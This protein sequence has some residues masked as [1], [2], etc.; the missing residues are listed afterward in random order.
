[1]NRSHL[2]VAY[3]LESARNRPVLVVASC[4]LL[5]LPCITGHAKGP[6][7]DPRA[8][9]LIQE[10]GLRESAVASR[11]QA[12]WKVP[13]RIVVATKDADRLKR[14]QAAA[15]GVEVLAAAD[16]DALA[17]QL[18]KAEAVIGLCN[19]K[20]LAAA[21]SLHWIQTWGVGVER[22]VA[23]PDLA[24]RG[25]VVTNMQRTS[26]IPIAEHAIAMMLSL[27]RAMPQFERRQQSG[28]WLDDTAGLHMR[29][30]TGQTMLVVGLGGIGTEVARRAHGLGMHVTAT[31]NSSREG[32]D[33]VDKVG[34]PGE[35]MA[36]AAQA[37]VV[38]NATPLT[39]ATTG[40][41]NKTFFA[42][43]K[44]GGI[45]INIARGR[46]VVTDDLLA[47]LRDGRLA[48]AGLDVT[49]PE[50]LPN[51]HPLWT[52]PNVIITPHVASESESQSERYLILAAENIRRYVAGEPLLN[53]VD[54][55]RGY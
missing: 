37:D 25:I 6:P 19:A 17:A 27:S 4:A 41:F 50:P 26:A 49:D 16:G 8:I 24:R 3:A 1:M 12:G 46:S 23:V 14:L 15:P 54:I 10:L 31:R 29:E 55:Q 30:L 42:T 18:E 21:K 2:H 36:L 39:A 22:C 52:M 44:P 51:G 53:V 48:G 47:A 28:Q 38:V 20:T 7:A 5:L 34:L 9:A 13:K 32:P 45:F 40:I 11:D 33:F 43:M 35:L